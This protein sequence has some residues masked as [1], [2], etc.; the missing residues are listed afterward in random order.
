M[1]GGAA[2]AVSAFVAACTRRT[3]SEDAAPTTTLDPTPACDDGDEITPEQTEGPYFTPNSP[4]KN[5]LFADVESGTKLVLTGTV[6]AT[7]C[8][9]VRRAL[10]DFWQCDAEGNYDNEGFRLRGHQFTD[11]QGRYELTTVEPG[12]YPGRT[13]HIHVKVQAPNGPVLTTQ[14]Y[15]PGVAENE[16][17]GIYRDECLID[18]GDGAGT[19]DFVIQ[20]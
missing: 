14:L 19:F 8:E 17:D 20:T 5:D 9:P 11:A 13:K 12:I 3:P 4:E 10:V 15:F 2:A 6:L 18:L 1:I 16:G 7:N